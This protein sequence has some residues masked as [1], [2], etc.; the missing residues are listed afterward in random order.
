MTVLTARPTAQ[1]TCGRVPRGAHAG[2][3]DAARRWLLRQPA[4]SRRSREQIRV[5]APG[6]ARRGVHAHCVYESA[7]VCTGWR[8]ARIHRGRWDALR[9]SPRCR[10]RSHATQPADAAFDDTRSGAVDLCRSA[11]LFR[12][13]GWPTLHATRLDT[14][15]I[16]SADRRQHGAGHRAGARRARDRGG[17]A[18]RS[19]RR[20]RAGRAARRT[21]R[22][23]ATHR[24]DRRQSGHRRVGRVPRVHAAGRVVEPGA[25]RAAAGITGPAA[26][27]RR[28]G[29]GCPARDRRGSGA[30]AGC[31]WRRRAA[32]RVA[33]PRL[34]P[35]V[36]IDPCW[37]GGRVYRR[38]RVSE[39]G[40]AGWQFA[41]PRTVPDTLTGFERHPD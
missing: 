1:A 8:A 24:Y 36:A 33:R 25:R 11:L 35:R 20:R 34:G 23:R 6:A 4:A 12:A 37:R 22:R 27:C 30:A 19:Q 41:S 29:Q 14:G 15:S 17:R 21:S 31:P 32:R 26:F 7:D 16:Q 18:V 13:G 39:T 5:R 38:R 3:G 28:S 10:G 2:A 9:G 40:N